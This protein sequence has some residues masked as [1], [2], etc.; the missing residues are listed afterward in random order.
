MKRAEELRR[1][2]EKHG[3]AFLYL[4][5]SQAAKGVRFLS[6]EDIVFTDPLTDLDIGT[7]FLEALPDGGRGYL[8]ARLYNDL[9]DV[10][11]P[12][13]IDLTF[14]QETNS[15]FAAQAIAGHC[16][17]EH[18]REGRFAYEERILTRAADF[19]PFLRQYLKEALN[20]GAG[21]V[22]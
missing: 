22:D 21:A 13:P 14:L 10:F 6:E 9:A 16:V 1:V 12:L 2:C 7:V 20:E 4:F 11:A 15:V 18:D 17:Y 3:V 8:Y 5:G 19:R